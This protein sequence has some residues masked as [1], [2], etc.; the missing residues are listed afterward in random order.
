VFYI[1]RNN[2]FENDKIGVYTVL[3]QTL[4]SFNN[5]N[6]TKITHWKKMNLRKNIESKLC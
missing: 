2:D 3:G 4:I 5:I 6:L 1:I